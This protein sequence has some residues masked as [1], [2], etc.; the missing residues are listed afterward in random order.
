LIQR[1]R[2]SSRFLRIEELIMNQIELSYKDLEYEMTKE[3]KKHERMVLSTSEGSYVTSRTIRCILKG[4]TIYHL[5]NQNSRKYKQIASNPKVALAHGNLQVEGF[6][7]LKGHP[8]RE[9]NT[10]FIEFIQKKQPEVYEYWSNR[11]FHYQGL[12]LIEVTPSRIALFKGGVFPS[13][14]SIYVLDISNEKAYK[15]IRGEYTK[16][17]Q[18]TF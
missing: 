18:P 11:H 10:A 14:T 13:E 2:Y 1:F 4:M 9:E 8:L 15:L 7:S 3:L 16:E 17:N 12:G 6:A 5:T